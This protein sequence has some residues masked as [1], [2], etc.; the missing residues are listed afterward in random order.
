MFRGTARGQDVQ[1]DLGCLSLVS[2]PPRDAL[3][4]RSLT[5]EFEMNLL[6]PICDHIDSISKTDSP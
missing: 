4:I 3:P 1:H 6:S 2:A 5:S